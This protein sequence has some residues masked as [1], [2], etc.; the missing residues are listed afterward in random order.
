MSKIIVDGVLS[1]I[2]TKVPPELKLNYSG[3]IRLLTKWH[4][5]LELNQNLAGAK[6]KRIR[7]TT[8]EKKLATMFKLIADLSEL[9][10]V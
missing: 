7:F 1:M 6:L 10:A 4:C 5:K 3:G 9:K 2:A 8:Y